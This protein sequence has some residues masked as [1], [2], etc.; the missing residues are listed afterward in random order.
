MIWLAPAARAQ[1]EGVFVDPG[2]PTGKEYAIPLDSA[3]RQA[4]PSGGGAGAAPPIFGEG[5]VPSAGG[6]GGVNAGPPAAGSGEAGAPREESPP[7]GAGDGGNASAESAA[8][9]DGAA[10]VAAATQNP[11]APSGGFGT[12]LIVALSAAGLLLA[13]GLAGLV[14]RRTRG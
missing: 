9:R 10:A 13:G 2:S 11:G 12:P 14:I 8:S 6:A 5:I 7:E 4:D 1:E 3:R